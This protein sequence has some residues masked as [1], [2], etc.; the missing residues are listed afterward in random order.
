MSLT[1]V[2]Q[3]ILDSWR[4]AISDLDDIVWISTDAQGDVRLIR[5]DSNTEGSYSAA[6]PRE[7]RAVGS[8]IE[9]I[10]RAKTLIRR[11]APGATISMLESIDLL[12]RA[13]MFGLDERGVHQIEKMG[14]VIDEIEDALGKRR[15]SAGE[16]DLA[17]IVEI[18][19]RDAAGELDWTQKQ[20][21]E[22]IGASEKSLNVNKRDGKPRH[23]LFCAAVA[24]RRC[25]AAERRQEDERRQD[26]ERRGRR[27]PKK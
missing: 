25:E 21:E 12:G 9:A 15:R 1:K 11:G 5:T 17:A 23:P 24:M 7:N 4:T 20:I 3:S 2:D 6:G 8:L 10:R 19:R 16:T 22:A 18:R 27:R 13:L 14:R 26:D